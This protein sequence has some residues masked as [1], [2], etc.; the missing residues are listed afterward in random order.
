ML[1]Y[2]VDCIPDK[3]YE[4][5]GMVQG[6]T[7]Q[8]RHIGKDIMAGFRNIVG[9]EMKGYTEMLD[10]AR[11]EATQRMVSRAE[12]LDADAILGIKYATSAITQGAA[13]ILAYGTAVK[14][15]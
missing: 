3:K 11:A 15:I 6:S 7:V 12:T 1:L 5:L 9:G 4:L 13:E 8:S 14:F 2:T 10:S